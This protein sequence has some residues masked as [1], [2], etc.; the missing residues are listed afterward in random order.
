MEDLNM[1]HVTHQDVKQDITR[2]GMAI[3]IEKDNTLT[4]NPIPSKA[5]TNGPGRRRT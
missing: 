3:N 4:M 2:F 5:R 1:H